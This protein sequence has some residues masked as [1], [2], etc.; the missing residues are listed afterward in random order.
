[1]FVSLQ[2]AGSAIPSTDIKHIQKI[3]KLLSQYPL[4]QNH[5]QRSSKSIAF[6]S[7]FKWTQQSAD[8]FHLPNY[9][10]SVS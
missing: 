9:H 8:L 6:N 4:I 3:N 5:L 2:R 1:M 7:S 10:I